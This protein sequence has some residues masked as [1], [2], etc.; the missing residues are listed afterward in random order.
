MAFKIDHYY[1]SLRKHNPETRE[2]K[3]KFPGS[4]EAKVQLSVILKK[5]AKKEIFTFTK[6]D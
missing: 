1:A 2:V 5:V 6:H 3:M 4:Y